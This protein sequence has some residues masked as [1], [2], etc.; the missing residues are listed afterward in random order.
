MIDGIRGVLGEKLA[1]N[2]GCVSWRI[3]VV[4]NPCVLSPQIRS[5]LPH[6]LPQTLHNDQTIMFIY[7]LALREKFVVD[8]APIVEENRRCVFGA[9]SVPSGRAEL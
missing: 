1:L 5:F 4:Q 3:I 6:F 9:N 2:D 8:D 7:G